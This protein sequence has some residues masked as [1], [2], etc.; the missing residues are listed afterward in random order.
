MERQW[1]ITREQRY[2]VP[3]QKHASLI[4]ERVDL[5]CAGLGAEK[6][7]SARYDERRIFWRRRVI[8]IV[9]ALGVSEGR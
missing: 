8:R 4:R 3:G 5:D 6:A 7:P 1:G 9:S 2:A